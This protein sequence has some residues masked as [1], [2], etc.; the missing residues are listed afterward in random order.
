[1]KGCTYPWPHWV[2]GE[3]LHAGGFALELGEHGCFYG[4]DYCDFRFSNDSDIPNNDNSRHLCVTKLA[5][6]S[7]RAPS[8]AVK[9]R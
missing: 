9:R 2:K 3:A 5:R 6:H 8:E 7:G 1:M 4:G